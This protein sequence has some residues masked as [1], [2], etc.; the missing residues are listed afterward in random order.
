MN[1]IKRLITKKASNP[2]AITQLIRL[3]GGSSGNQEL[4][5]TLNK[6]V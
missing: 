1:K 3:L 4:I 5:D 6:I 2:E